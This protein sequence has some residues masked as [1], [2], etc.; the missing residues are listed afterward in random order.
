MTPEEQEQV[1]R[2]HSKA[3]DLKAREKA[4]SR[5]GELMEESYI[6]DFPADRALI[7]ELENFVASA[8]APVSLKGKAKRLLKKYKI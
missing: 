3:A 7:K 8:S 6:L 4:L 2:I 5:L 1:R